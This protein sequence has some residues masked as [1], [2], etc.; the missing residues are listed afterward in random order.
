MGFESQ[1]QK[2]LMRPAHFQ[3]HL[4]CSLNVIVRS[5]SAL[6][7]PKRAEGPQGGKA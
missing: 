1:L 7:R 4:E 3:L 6:H 5:A 2:E